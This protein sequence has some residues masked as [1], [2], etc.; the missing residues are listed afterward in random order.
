MVNRRQNGFLEGEWAWISGASSG[1]GEAIALH[2]AGLGVGVVISARSQDKLNA[3]AEAIQARGGK[4]IPLPLDITDFAAVKQAEHKIKADVGRL[5]VLI[6][7]AGRELMLPFNISSPEKWL[8]LW[9][10]QVLGAFEM[11][12]TALPMLTDSGARNG[13]QGRVVFISSTVALRGWPS[14]S[15][16]S[17]C[18]AGILGGMRSLAAELAP[19]G[20]RVNAVTPGMVHTDMQKRMFARMPKDNQ[21][22]IESAH[23]LGMGEPADVAA[24]VAFLASYESK[25]ITGESLVVDGGLTLK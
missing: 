11:V 16:Y 21:D 9:E 18:K 8:K 25:W 5:D 14:L 20:I 4:A 12:R 13:G 3:V 15:V 17:A 19:K 24:A 23:L 1:I 10:V 2:L 6:P 22:A 7:C